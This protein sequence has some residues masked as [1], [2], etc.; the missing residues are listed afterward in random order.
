MIDA[1][2]TS[3]EKSGLSAKMALCVAAFTMVGIDGEFKEE[4]L[5]KLRSLIHTDESAF[6]KA[7]SFYNERPLDVCIKVVTAKLN[8][9][10][11]RITYH[12]L[13]DLAQVDRDFALSEQDLL[14][15]YAA[16]FRL[17]KKYISSVKDMPSHKYN[18][19]AFE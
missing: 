7:I 6:V 11:K 17:D 4:E 12:I 9:E 15:Q 10:Q 8:D 5:Q 14:E 3:E 18:L 1:N 2:S 13:Y 16:E 19:A